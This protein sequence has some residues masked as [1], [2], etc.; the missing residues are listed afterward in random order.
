MKKSRNKSR[1]LLIFV[2]LQPVLF[3]MLTMRKIRCIIHFGTK[4][5]KR[6]ILFYSGGISIKKILLILLRLLSIPYVYGVLMIT[7]LLRK[8]TYS[9]NVKPPFWEI[10]ELIKGNEKLLFDI[11]GNILM[12][13]PLGILLPLFFRKAD[14]PKK[15][16]LIGFIVSLLIEITQLITTRGY[17]EIDDLFHN[18]LGAFLGAFIGCSA[19]KWIYS[20]GN[21]HQ[22][23]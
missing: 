20:D 13:L 9:H 16:A 5:Y 19:A 1:L 6:N 3:F 7:L 21:G 4:V 15:I 14:I 22:K 18:T 12:L 8:P 17:F 11:I 23:K 2:N 10:T